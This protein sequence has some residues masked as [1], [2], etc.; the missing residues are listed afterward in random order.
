MLRQQV[1]ILSHRSVKG[2]CPI[3]EQRSSHVS[4]WLQKKLAVPAVM[5]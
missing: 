1:S 2:L 3:Y 5:K 4:D